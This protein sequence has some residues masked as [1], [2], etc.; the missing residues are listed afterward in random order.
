MICRGNKYGPEIIRFDELD[1]SGGDRIFGIGES[2]CDPGPAPQGGRPPDPGIS[3]RS[4]KGGSSLYRVRVCRG[5]GPGGRRGLF[6][7]SASGARYCT[8]PDPCAVEGRKRRTAGGSLRVSADSGGDESEEVLRRQCGGC[9][10][11]DGSQ[12]D[13]A[14]GGF[15][16]LFYCLGAPRH[17]GLSRRDLQRM[18][19]KTSSDAEA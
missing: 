2:P 5:D 3:P 16:S 15:R 17:A 6:R 10:P 19:R 8:L 14:P 18:G 11:V 12:T 4:S 13:G 9:K 7:M 1:R